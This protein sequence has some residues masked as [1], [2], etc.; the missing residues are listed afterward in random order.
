MKEGTHDE[1]MEVL[2]ALGATLAKR[3]SELSMAKFDVER[4]R[5]KLEE[6]EKE[7]TELKGE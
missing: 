3:K 2:A 4:L 7:I 5:K 1:Y 6:A